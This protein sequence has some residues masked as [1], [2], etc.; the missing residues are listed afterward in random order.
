M[1]KIWLALCLAS[2][3]F[4][5]TAHDFWIQ[6]RLF[7]LPAPNTDPVTL[8]VGHGQARDRWGVDRDHV[9]LFS[10]AGPDGLIDRKPNLTLGAPSFDALVPLAKPGAYVLGLQSTSTVSQL[11]FLRFNDYITT[12]GITPIIEA[13]RKAGQDKADGRELYS[14][15]AKA[16]IQIGPVDRAS[17]ARVTRPINLALEIVPER[18]PLALAPGNRMPVR[19]LSNGRPLAGALV[20]LTDLDADAEP[21]AKIRTGADGRATFVIPHPGKWQMN[22]VWSV[23]LVG[24]P[25]ADFETTFSSL[26]FGTAQ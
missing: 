4:P 1:R 17:I 12:E 26:S 23:P 25:K 10:T 22:I 15:R 11:P 20:K 9:V 6:P 19:V 8:L 3:A 24:N 18:H 5:A 13:R 2:V 7:V 21:V 16:I 14:R